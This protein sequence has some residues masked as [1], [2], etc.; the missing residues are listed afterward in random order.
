MMRIHQY[1]ILCASIIA[2]EAALEALRNGRA[3]MERMRTEYERRR[4]FLVARFNAMGLSCHEPRGAFYVFPSIRSTGLSSREFALKLLEEE[5]VA[6]V[7]GDAFGPGGE[8][9]VRCS[10]ATSM[11]QIQVAVERIERFLHRL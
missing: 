3:A 1:S 6:V 7:P 11:E 5:K 8:G 10:Y 4:N 9:Y 2:Q